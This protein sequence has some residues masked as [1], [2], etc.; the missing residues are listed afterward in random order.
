M[1]R[2]TFFWLLAFGGFAAV[3]LLCGILVWPQLS[4]AW[5]SI[6]EKI[7][8]FRRQ[9]PLIK[10]VLLL[11]VGAFVVYGST[12]TNLVDCVSG[13][14]ESLP[15]QMV[16]E[17]PLTNGLAEVRSCSS[18]KD[19]ASP[20]SASPLSVTPEDIARGW[21]LWEVRTNSNV[22]Y[23]MPDGATL[24]SNW[25][26]RGAY[27]DV[28]PIDFGSWRF[29]FSTNEYSSLWAFTWGKLRFV[30]G[31]AESEIAAVGAPMSA[32]PYRSRLWSA[33]ETPPPKAL[34]NNSR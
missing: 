11:F 9:P 26:V 6:E 32:V 27:E 10:L 31:D 12:K 33:A 13:E 29:Q 30:L 20:L 16:V 28:K 7:D 3:S 8:Q 34:C 15:L 17:R 5:P 19:S 18:G 23:T 25:W 14:A 1:M 2:S 24:A 22:C 4:A 21:Q